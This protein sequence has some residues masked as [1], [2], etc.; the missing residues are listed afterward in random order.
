M[1]LPRSVFTNCLQSW[2]E[3]CTTVLE[4]GVRQQSASLRAALLLYEQSSGQ[5]NS[6]WA[7]CHFSSRMEHVT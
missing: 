3:S 1:E 5:F 4:V 2:Q 7:F 6:L